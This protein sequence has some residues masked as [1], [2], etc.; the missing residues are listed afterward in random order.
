MTEYR[1]A[2]Q[3]PAGTVVATATDAGVTRLAFVGDAPADG[4]RVHRHLSRLAGEL[5][6]YFAGDLTGFSVPVADPVGTPFQ[7]AAWRYLRSIPFGQTR[8]YGQQAAAIR[9]PNAARAVGRANGAN[10]LCL[11]L[12]CHR[13]VGATGSLAGFAYGVHR[14]LWLLH[15]ERRVAGIPLDASPQFS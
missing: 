13:V 3:T 14:K 11:L 9:A 7:V 8:T 10:P 6:R 4:G 1:A 5:D 15:H 2:I 12:P